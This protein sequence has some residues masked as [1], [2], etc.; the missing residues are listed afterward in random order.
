M[1]KSKYQLI[2]VL[3]ALLLLLALALFLQPASVQAAK[4]GKLLK[5]N[6]T[7]KV[8]INGGK[9][10]K[11]RYTTRKIN[12]YYGEEFQL[13]INKK[14]VYSYELPSY[15]KVNNVYL[16]DIKKSDRYKE[17]VVNFSG[18]FSDWYFFVLRYG[19]NKKVTA[20]VDQDTSGALTS[21]RMSVPGNKKVFSGKGKFYAIVETPFYSNTF[22]CYY[23]KAPVKLT[24]GKIKFVK[25]SS[26]TLT[27]VTDYTPGLFGEKYY[28]TAKS[29]KLYKKASLDASYTERAA[30]LRFT[31]KKI[32]I[33]G[34]QKKTDDG[35][36]W[37]RYHLFVQVKTKDGKTGWLYFP[38]ESTEK[39]L[40]IVP[41]WG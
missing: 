10:E 36:D 8:D 39:Y 30:G 1:K 33:A 27:N 22:G 18:D 11:I 26:Y 29:M 21:G 17:I 32:K 15:G 14:L 19:K 40:T 23:I 35:Y 34:T 28:I 12:E 20:F 9:K 13:Y 41:Q 3:P 38:A 31:P 6:K 24:G 37:E 4:K 5:K 16:A 25:S 2:P 7:Y